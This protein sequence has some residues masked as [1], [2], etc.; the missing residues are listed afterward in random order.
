MRTIGLLIAGH[1]EELVIAK[2][3]RSA[4]K[5]GMDR[6]NIFFVNDASTDNTRSVVS[7]ILPKSNIL[8]VRRS[9][10]GLA[11]KKASKKFNLC[12]RYRWIHIADADGGF[13]PKYFTTLRKKLNA[14]HAA[15]TGYVRSL[16]G[17]NVS[18]F[19]VFEYTIGLELHRRFQTLFNVV[20]VIPGPSSIFRNDVFGQLNFA[21][22]S[23]TEDFD[24]T[25]QLHRKKLGTVQFIPEAIAYTQDPQTIV[26]LTKQLTRWNR[27]TLISS[28]HHRIGRRAQAI[29]LYLSYQIIQNL[30]FVVNYLV[31]VPYIAYRRH[32][33]AIV[34]A[35]FLWDVLLSAVLV[36]LVAMRSKRFDVISAFPLVYVFR[37]ISVAV[38]MKAYIEVVILRKFRTTTNASIW[39][40]T[41]RYVTS[42]Q[43]S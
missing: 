35:A 2:T 32:S 27:G 13:A 23:M 33:L 10:K 11:L 21:N 14:K 5:A 3:I 4:I 26:D 25:L 18:Q 38:F 22:G 20:P 17:S 12:A 30:L 42:W 41:S 24:V 9:G 34:A 16:P 36:V 31:L 1:N 8:H 40:N 29:D 37:W 15:A 19:R 39:K 6:D 7:E 43:T 28:A